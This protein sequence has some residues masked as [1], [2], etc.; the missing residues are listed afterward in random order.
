MP[1]PRGRPRRPAPVIPPPCDQQPPADP[2]TPP[3]QATPGSALN[4][5]NHAPLPVRPPI[6]INTAQWWADHPEAAERFGVKVPG[7]TISKRLETARSTIG[8]WMPWFLETLEE[9]GLVKAAA[10]RAGV[11]KTFCYKLKAEVKEF[12]DLWEDAMEGYYNRIE[13]ALG[14]AA[15]NGVLEPMAQ[16][17]GVVTTWG[18]KKDLKAGQVVLAARRPDAFNVTRTEVTGKN[19]GPIEN[20]IVLPSVDK[21]PE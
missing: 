13:A 21:L 7:G 3:V 6:Q 17:R 5:F 18:Y 12:A 8:R 19:Q 10:Q 14:D 15:V 16:Y 4:S 9:T 2:V 11:P 1:N 20:V